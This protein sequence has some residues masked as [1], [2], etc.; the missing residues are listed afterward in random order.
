MENLELEAQIREQPTIESLRVYGDWL[1]QHGDP[2]GELVAIQAALV[3]DPAS[4]KLRTREAQLFAAHR[5]DWLGP[6]AELAREEFRCTWSYGFID[7]VMFGDADVPSSGHR[8]ARNIRA[9]GSQPCI[10]LVRG[11]A[12]G[13]ED[14]PACVDALASIAARARWLSSLAIL[15]ASPAS[16]PLLELPDDILERLRVLSLRNV[17]ADFDGA[18]LPALRRLVLEGPGSWD[19]RRRL[20]QPWP[21]LERLEIS[22][23]NLDE[24]LEMLVRSP[25]LRQLRTLDL[26]EGTM[27][28]RGEQTLIANAALFAHLD[29]LNL[30]DLYCPDLEAPE[31]P[32]WPPPAQDAELAADQWAHAT[33]ARLSALEAALPNVVI[34]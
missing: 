7:W 31:R 23:A 18:R 29:E 8:V 34:E 6:L 32:D 4:A 15:G 17:D 26:M 12:I 20:Q 2:R 1:A 22:D 16:M 5:R 28:S 14:H 13:P 21:S 3:N 24:L 33:Q 10:G 30:A 19:L 9:L 25:L 27:T 11:I